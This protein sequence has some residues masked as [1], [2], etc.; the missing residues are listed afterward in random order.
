MTLGPVSRQ[1]PAV[2]WCRRAAR[3]SGGRSGSAA[4]ELAQRLEPDRVLLDLVLSGL[5]GLEVAWQPTGARRRRGDLAAGA[6]LP[7]GPAAHGAGHVDAARNKL[8]ALR[9]AFGQDDA[10]VYAGPPASP[11]SPL[12]LPSCSPDLLRPVPY[13][14]SHQGRSPTERQH[15]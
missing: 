8:A 7:P 1:G 14:P 6:A 13:D 12:I 2:W 4:L 5:S 15:G 3:S 9:R 11:D 10:S